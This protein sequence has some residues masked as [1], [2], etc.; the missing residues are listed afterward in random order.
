MADTPATREDAAVAAPAL[1][2]YDPNQNVELEAFYQK[3][4]EDDKDKIDVEIDRGNI[5]FLSGIDEFDTHRIQRKNDQGMF[6]NEDAVSLDKW[7]LKN[8]YGFSAKSFDRFCK[9]LGVPSK[10]MNKCPDYIVQTVIEHFLTAS[11]SGRILLRCREREGNIKTIRGICGPSYVPLDNR[12]LWEIIMP[13]LM[14]FEKRT[15]VKVRIHQPKLSDEYMHTRILFEDQVD[16][17]Y[18]GKKDPFNTG[19]HISNSELGYIPVRADMITFRLVCTNGMVS[20]ADGR[21]LFQFK[22]NNAD[23]KEFREQ[24][25]T[26]LNFAIDNRNKP[27]E[28]IQSAI[29]KKVENPS[30]VIRRIGRVHQVKNDLILD[31]LNEYEEGVSTSRYEDTRMDV[32]NAFTRVAQ[33]AA[34]TIGLRLEAVAGRVLVDEVIWSSQFE[35]DAI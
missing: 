30:R 3:I 11:G 4:I 13:E 19:I 25:I 33:T 6:D 9:R 34:P 7:E 17:G 23:K 15:G 29:M 2:G 10:F 20:M 27:L 28:I 12:E 24:L 16:V 32:V 1:G 22:Q 18:G 35:D 14:A 26:Q 5:E 8:S 21:R 31:V